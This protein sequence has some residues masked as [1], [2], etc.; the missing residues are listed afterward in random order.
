MEWCGGTVM[1]CG[2]LCHL[3]Y[4]EKRFGKKAELEERLAT[5]TSCERRIDWRSECAFGL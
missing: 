2:P 1:E 5:A 3:W 4:V